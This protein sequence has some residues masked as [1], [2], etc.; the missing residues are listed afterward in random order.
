MLGASRSLP[1]VEGGGHRYKLN[2][3]DE[4]SAGV[5]GV[6]RLPYHHMDKASVA[7]IDISAA[8]DYCA[9]RSWLTR[10]WSD[11]INA[12]RF[13]AVEEQELWAS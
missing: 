13:E 6:P 4:G 2:I 11:E 9:G 1:V 5:D 10:E 3:I 8:A 12:E 7:A